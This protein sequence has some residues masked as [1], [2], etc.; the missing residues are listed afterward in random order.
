MAINTVQ[1]QKGMSIQEFMKQYG[2][3]A[4]CI[5][6]LESQRWP[7]G[8]QCR[9]CS[10]KKHCIL[11]KKRLYQCSACTRQTSVTAGTIFHSTKLSLT[12]WFLAIHFMTQS[13]NGISQLELAN[14]LSQQSTLVNPTNI[15]AQESYD[16]TNSY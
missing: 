10:S 8:F 14:H 13:K 7:N 2:T 6:A 15:T 3:E 1:L 12:K 5:G 11:G 4:Q 9:F 16:N